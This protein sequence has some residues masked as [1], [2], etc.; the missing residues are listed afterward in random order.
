VDLGRTRSS[1]SVAA[2][3]WIWKG[4]EARL[5][6]LLRRCGGGR[7]H[8]RAEWAA[9]RSRGARVMCARCWREDSSAL[10]DEEVRSAESRSCTELQHRLGQVGGELSRGCDEKE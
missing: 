3:G 5:K 6:P 8:E 2:Q 10:S 7:L 9:I 4:W 1:T